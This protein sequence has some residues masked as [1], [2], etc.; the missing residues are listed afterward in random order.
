MNSCK[1]KGFKEMTKSDCTAAQAKTKA[2]AAK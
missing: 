2:D 1:G